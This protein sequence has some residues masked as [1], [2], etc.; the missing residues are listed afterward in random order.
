MQQSIER[1]FGDWQKLI[2]GLTTGVERHQLEGEAP[3]L[4]T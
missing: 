1:H 4:E 3:K 2:V